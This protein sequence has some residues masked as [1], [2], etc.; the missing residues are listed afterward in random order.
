M[1]SRKKTDFSNVR[2]WGTVLIWLGVLAWAPFFFALATGREV[3]IFPFLTLHLTGVLGGAWLRSRADRKAAGPAMQTHGRR[4]RIV[5]RLMIYLGVLAWAPYFYL[6]RIVGLEVEIGPFLAAH[7][8]GV[9]GG[10]AL[11]VSVELD[12]FFRRK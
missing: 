2:T 7:L 1:A 12:R 3:S 9:L 6:E 10:T 4:R 11:R 5:S 8:I